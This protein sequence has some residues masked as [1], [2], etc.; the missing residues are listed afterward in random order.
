MEEMERGRQLE[1]T[2]RMITAVSPA[3]APPG[4]AN[5]NEKGKK[6]NNI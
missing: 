1:T 2:T 4:I 3:A 5:E 6:K